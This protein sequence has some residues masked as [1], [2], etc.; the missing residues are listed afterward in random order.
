MSDLSIDLIEN[1]TAFEPGAEMN[2][3]AS[4]TL[5]RPA[6]ALELRLFWFTRGKGTEDTGVVATQRFEQPLAQE[7]RSFHFRLPQVPY[8][9][10]GKLISLIWALEL[11]AYPSKEV[12]RREIVLAPGGSEVRLESVQPRDGKRRFSITT[13]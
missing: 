6:H 13:Q 3:S 11:V 9:F 1:R 7:S 10:S 12:A 4:W 8:S 2:G 5:D